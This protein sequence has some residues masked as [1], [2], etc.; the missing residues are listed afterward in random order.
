MV[1]NST[2][3]S[4]DPVEVAIRDA[5]CGGPETPSELCDDLTEAHK[6][7]HR[8]LVKIGLIKEKLTYLVTCPGQTGS[9][10][11]V[12]TFGGAYS[13]EFEQEHVRKNLEGYYPDDWGERKRL[14]KPTQRIVWLTDQGLLAKQDAIGANGLASL[15]ML[16]EI[17]R[18]PHGMPPSF[19]LNDITRS[20]DASQTSGNPTVNNYTQNN[21]NTTNVNSLDPEIGPVIT[22]ISEGVEETNVRLSSLPEGIAHAIQS[23]GK[24]SSKKPTINETMSGMIA[25]D[26]SLLGLNSVQWSKKLSCAKSTVTET[27]CWK[28][29]CQPYQQMRRAEV[30][31]DRYA[32]GQSAERL[33]SQPD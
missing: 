32:K 27:A 17:Y 1:D 16:I 33:K 3:V 6:I 15:N 29:Q 4:I 7:A 2:L 12:A 18:S 8:F 14:Y 13:L 22:K 26:P 20:D 24:K 11:L 21:Y 30:E 31:A 28:N 10:Q 5:I 19:E 25:K 9:I 23:S